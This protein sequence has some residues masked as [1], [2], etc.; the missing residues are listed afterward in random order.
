MCAQAPSTTQYMPSSSPLH[1]LLDIRDNARNAQKWTEDQTRES[2]RDNLMI[3][4]AVTR[5]LEIV[6]EASRRLP[7]SIRDKHPELPWRAIMDVGNVYRHAYDNVSED[8]VWR[9]VRQRLPELLAV[10]EEEIAGQ[11]QP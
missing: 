5:C 4:Y 10:I 9:T 1:S 6:S 11:P 2:F 3:I 8:A 7:Q